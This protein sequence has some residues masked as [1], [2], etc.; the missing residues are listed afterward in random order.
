MTRYLDNPF[1]IF[2]S[3][4]LLLLFSA[5]MLNAEPQS[6]DTRAAK[7]DPVLGERI[8]GGIVF[9]GKLWLRGVGGS[10]RDFEGG[11]ISLSLADGSRHAH[12]EGGVVDIKRVGHDLCVLRF[13]SPKGRDTVL[14][15]WRKDRFEDLATFSSPQ[16]DQ[17]I[18]LV[19]GANGPVVLSAQSIRTSSADRR[20]FRRIKLKGKLRGGF[21]WTADS[22]SSGD[23]L[24]V[25]FNTGEWGGGLQRVD[26]RTGIVSDIE[27]RDTKELCA[28]PLNS[29]CDPVTGVIPDPQD[30]NC[31]LV[32]V[33]LA[34][35][36]SDGRILRVCGREVNL[37]FEKSNLVDGF[38]GNKIKETEPFFGLVP[39]DDGR[40]W[41]ITSRALYRFGADGT[42]AEEYALPELKPVSGIYLSRELPGVIVVRTDANWAVSV[43]GFTPLVIPMESKLP[44]SK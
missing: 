25:G 12:F 10:R 11:L 28:G 43:S 8:T 27:R 20:E 40:F 22:P 7:G 38:N 6:P 24:Y 3:A 42:K 30:K 1:A 17:P 29:A 35:M 16:K 36:M 44:E 37:V 41:G 33:G 26:L 39:D 18:A 23:S 4:S 13:T 34:H 21:Q 14:S 2:S 5:L 15:V 31:V 9:D 19:D 32:T